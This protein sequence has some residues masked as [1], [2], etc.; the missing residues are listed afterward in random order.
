MEAYAT[1]AGADLGFEDP[2]DVVAIAGFD[3]EDGPAEPTEDRR[4][5][6]NRLLVRLC[7]AGAV[8]AL[9]LGAGGIVLLRS[10]LDHASSPDKVVAAKY[11]REYRHCV[12][13]GGRQRSCADRA[14]QRCLADPHWTKE[15]GSDDAVLTKMATACLMGPDRAG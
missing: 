6:N 10:Y 14:E 15:T 12:L 4:R 5:H 1:E 11:Q 8:L 7:I 3:G 2:A 9:A 13:D